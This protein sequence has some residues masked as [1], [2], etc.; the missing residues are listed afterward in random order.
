[1]HGLV[2][3]SQGQMVSTG[4][5]QPGMQR[6][7]LSQLKT[8]ASVKKAGVNLDA[9]GLRLKW[10][11]VSFVQIKG[12]TLYQNRS[13]TWETVTSGSYCRWLNSTGVGQKQSIP[14]TLEKKKREREPSKKS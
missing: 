4:I 1:M 2:I 3:A 11:Q 8:T 12:S 10:K 7:D 6:G 5:L 13:E 9:R 14:P